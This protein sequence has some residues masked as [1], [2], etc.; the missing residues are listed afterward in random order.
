[1]NNSATGKARGQGYFVWQRL[2]RNRGA[3]LGLAFLC[4]MAVLMIGADFLFDYDEVVIKQTISERL[5]G[6]S[7]AHWFGTDESGRDILARVVHG[8]R[9][10]VL[11]SAAAVLFATFVGGALGAIA[12]FLMGILCQHSP[13]LHRGP[14]SGTHHWIPRGQ[15]QPPFHLTAH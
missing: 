7:A 3:M 6:P 12:G 2:K 4:F 14:K 5:Q 1:M 9:R 13:N 8:A 10:S 11:I 15:S